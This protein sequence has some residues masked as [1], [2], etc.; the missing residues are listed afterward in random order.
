MKHAILVAA[1]FASVSL[2]AAKTFPLKAGNGMPILPPIDK[3]TTQVKDGT[4]TLSIPAGMVYI[5]AGKFIFGESETRG[6][7]AFA[8]ARFEV[9]NAEYKA[10]LDAT[11]HH[12]VPRYWKAGVYPTGKANHPV[13]FVSLDDAQAYCA[14]VGSQTG[15]K[16][17]V[18]SAEQW[19]K[20]AR[21]PHGA[22]STRGSTTTPT[23]A[24]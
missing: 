9:T 10:F 20:A 15:R 6:L 12:G 21:G 4:R 17:V 18:P 13:L 23:P 14:W 1:A 16:I 11:G 24:L 5:P 19:E 22:V 3:A 8:M 7:P 2:H